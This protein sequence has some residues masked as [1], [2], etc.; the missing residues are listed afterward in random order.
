MKIE[1]IELLWESDSKIDSVDLKGESLKIPQLHQKYF[2]ILN[3]EILTF[4]YLESQQNI[5]RKKLW[6]YYTGISIDENKNQVFPVKKGQKFTKDDINAF[7][8][9]D[10][11]YQNTKLK[12]EYH[13]QI[14]KYLESIIKEISQRTWN[15][16]NAIEWHKF[17]NPEH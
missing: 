8:D 6:A 17:T 10:Q 1:E 2:K 12:M 14:I 15:I 16:K 7:I 4:K 13:E 5:I 9:G 3:Q 11:E